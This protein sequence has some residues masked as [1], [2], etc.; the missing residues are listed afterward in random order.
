MKNNL[1]LC[2]AAM[3][4]GSASLVY[5]TA[6]LMACSTFKLQKGNELIYGHNLNEGDMGVPGMIFINKRGVFKNGRTF[7]ELI[8]KDGKNPSGYSWISRYGSIS[9]NNLGR[10]L[11][12]GGMNE[13]GLYIWEMNEEADYPQNDSLPRLMHANWMQ[14][15]LDNCLT[16]DE[17][18]SSASAFQIDGWTWHYFISDASGD[19]ASLAFIGGKVKVNRGRE[20][21]V[22][23]LFNTP[24]DREMEVLRYYKGFG[25]LYDIE[26]NNPNVP[27]FVKTAA[28]LR[29]FDPSRNIDP[30][31]GAVDYG[32]EMLKN[33]T[34]YDEP[35]WSIII[36]AKRRNVYYKTRLNP[37]IK[38]FSMD[39]L[40]FSNN[41][42]TLIQDMDTPKGGD[43]LAM[44]QPYSTQTMKSFLATKLIPLL[45]K[46]MITSGGLT[47]DEFADR[48]ACITDKAELP[49][50]Q[51]FAGVWKTKPAATKDD[52]EI[53][54]RLRTNKNAVSGEIVFNKGESAYPITHIGLLGNRLTFTYKNKRGYLL[55]VQAT[56]NNNQLTAHLQTTE[57]DAGT[58]VLY[59]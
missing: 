44:F 11:P 34:V 31:R 21:P 42:A 18:I 20:M 13:A 45:P 36:D 37:T 9:F 39:A 6:N 14:F 40:D 8:N 4:V 28:M 55:D 56:I 59:K 57:E 19:C 29:D 51:Y 22:A 32:F 30:S 17:A 53:E 15:V 7:S 5:P 48:F 52:L 26:M 2:I 49:A 43:V 41:S 24:Y 16:L 58:F 3:V 35:E 23:G 54:I 25:G 38:S 12:D 33:I 1:F 10:D 50:N 47:P 27:R 46:E